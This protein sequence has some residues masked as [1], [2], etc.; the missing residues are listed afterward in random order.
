MYHKSMTELDRRGFMAVAALAAAAAAAPPAEARPGRRPRQP[1]L[2]SG[3]SPT[4]PEVL[5][6][7]AREQGQGEAI[8]FLDLAAFDNNLGIV[9]RFAREQGWALRPS[10]KS[11]QSPRLIA[12]TLQR[13][14]EPRG[15]VFHLRHVPAIL[16]A[17][18]T[19]TDLMTGYPP[20]FGELQA[21]LGRRR[22]K[23]PHRIRVLIDSVELLQ[24]YADLARTARRKGPHEVALQLEGGMHLSGIRTPEEMTQAL[25]ILRDAR[26]RLKLT[27]VLC[28]DGYG[29]FNANRQFR[30][31]MVRDC[32]TRWQSWLDQLAVEG[33][34]LYDPATLV[35]NGPA[36]SSYQL[37]AGSKIPN[38]ISPGMAI[39]YT[40]YI[41]GDGY[42]NEGL[43]PVLRHAAPV[44]RLPGAARLPL[45]G[46]PV[47]NLE[48][49]AVKGG[50]WPSHDGSPDTL[51]YPSSDWEDDETKGGRGNNESKFLAQ[52]PVPVKRGDYVILDVK[53]SGD[54]IDHFDTVVAVR[55]G[56][57]RRVWPTLRRPGPAA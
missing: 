42:E 53:H 16:D 9:E 44:H 12:Y 39:F 10:L 25:K 13:L 50:A 33:A 11:F 38:E 21:F 52:P 40:G 51:L 2:G 55:E 24:R 22:H 7:I 31:N 28:Y 14:R 4:P 46:T 29:S 57:I 43:L 48:S 36:S 41:R 26:D 54:A 49:V 30:E 37:Y 45:T 23:R 27:A 35:R 34:D 8:C 3:G 15:L 47:A 32:L 20:S 5:A 56:T 6:R 18:P 19:G 17:A 1:P